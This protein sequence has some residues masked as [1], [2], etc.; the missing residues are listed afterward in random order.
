MAQQQARGV[1]VSFSG[2]DGQGRLA[3]CGFGVGWGR[4]PPHRLR[5][6]RGA[7]LDVGGGRQQHVQH[8]KP[9][10][11]CGEVDGLVA[12]GAGRVESGAGVDQRL[13]DL[14]RV[15]RIAVGASGVQRAPGM[16]LEAAPLGRERVH[17]PGVEADAR[18]RAVGIVAERQQRAHRR[19]LPAHQGEAQRRQVLRERGKRFAT[20]QALDVR[21]PPERAGAVQVAGDA[22]LQ[23]PRSRLVVV[24]RRRLQC[25][26]VR[27]RAEAHCGALLGRPGEQQGA[28]SVL[29]VIQCL[30]QCSVHPTAA[31]TQRKAATGHAARGRSQA[32][33]GSPPEA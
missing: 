5:D 25:A 28:A 8:C 21:H 29:A 18:Q 27:I 19:Q 30:A 32:A 12:Q 17:L 14:G 15:W 7:R 16:R 1:G 13:G 23:Q 26:Q 6:G 9:A 20:Y 24:E 22:P 3:E 4:Q 2:G 33:C 11:R 31:G 10:V